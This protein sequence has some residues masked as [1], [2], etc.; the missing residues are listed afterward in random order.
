MTWKISVLFNRADVEGWSETYYT[1]LGNS[2]YQA[3]GSLSQAINARLQCLSVSC[4]IWGYRVSQVGVRRAS[5]L[6]RTKTSAVSAALGLA[7]GNLP[8]DVG[9]VGVQGVF[10]APNGRS[11]RRLFRGLP[12]SWISWSTEV[13]RMALQSAGLG[14]L[15]AFVTLL[16]AA[17]SGAG[18]YYRSVLDP[19]ANGAAQ[20]SAVT[21]NA[22]G[23]FSATVPTPFVPAYGNPLIFSGFRKPSAGI[24][25]TFAMSEWSITGT[26][27][28]VITVRRPISQ[29]A[30]SAYVG[31]GGWVRRADP[32][33]TNYV[34]STTADFSLVS[35]RNIG[36]PFGQRRGRRLVS[37]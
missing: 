12:D 7:A 17:A 22:N 9:S 37:R 33:F 2:A 6:I 21:A 20:V 11:E 26:G 13:Q 24:N 30:A 16:T 35:T 27:P 18:W 15:N 10:L 36:R 5:T 34:V 19:A 4:Y 29:E 25:G 1:T 14:P 23:T 31:V 3:V 28:Y 8:S 32:T